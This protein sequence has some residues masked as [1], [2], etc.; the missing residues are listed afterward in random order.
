MYEY[1]L[2]SEVADVKLEKVATANKDDFAKYLQASLSSVIFSVK[3][4]MTAE[5]QGGDWEIVS[6]QL[7]NLDRYLVVTFLIRRPEK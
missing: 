6:H 1:D 4:R 3:Q 2:I 7:N 5:F